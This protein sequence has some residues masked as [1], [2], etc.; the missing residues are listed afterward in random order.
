MQKNSVNK[1][2]IVGRLGRTPETKYTAS[3]VA[4]CSFS[5]ATT[6]VYKEE[7]KTEWHNI[8]AFGKTGEFVQNY[9]D[10]GAL[11]YVEGRIETRSWDDKDGNK[12]YK[13]GIIANIITPLGKATAGER[14]ENGNSEAIEALPF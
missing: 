10:K 7:E 11:V 6:E 12:R 3:Q 4:I 1:A 14:Q 9:L 13:T 5:V 2:V 8:T